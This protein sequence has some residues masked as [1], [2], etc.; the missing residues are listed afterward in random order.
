MLGS[1][2]HKGREQK[3]KSKLVKVRCA[4]LAKLIEEGGLPP[5]VTFLSLDVEGNEA[6]VMR[7]V[8]PKAFKVMIAETWSGVSKEN[9]K[10]A[11]EVQSVVTAG[12]LVE[13]RRLWVHMSRTYIHP[14]VVELPMPGWPSEGRSGTRLPDQLRRHVITDYMGRGMTYQRH[15]DVQRMSALAKKRYDRVVG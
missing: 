5:K 4:P 7:T 11:G 9:I 10:L 2:T 14:T 8:D 1:S 15:P 3:K 12:G 13:S 6:K